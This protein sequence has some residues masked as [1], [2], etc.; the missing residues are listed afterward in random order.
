[1][2]DRQR[3]IWMQITIHVGIRLET[4]WRIE[5]AAREGGAEKEAY[6]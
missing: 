4:E 1:M 3:A 2:L 6:A 5:A